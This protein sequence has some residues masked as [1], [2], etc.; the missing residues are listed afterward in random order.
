MARR[1]G[2]AD[3]DKYWG[4]RIWQRVK[5]EPDLPGD[6]VLKEV[7]QDPQAAVER[8]R[9]MKARGPAGRRRRGK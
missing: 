5:S 2:D 4:W 9:K 3:Y 1:K 7:G 8:I 6:L